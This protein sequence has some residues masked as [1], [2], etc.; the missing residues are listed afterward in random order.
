MF[1][2]FFDILWL[3]DATW[4]EDR[5]LGFFEGYGSSY[6]SSS[7]SAKSVNKSSPAIHELR[8]KEKDSVHMYL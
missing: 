8:V 2:F 6:A 7:G 3:E 1:F 5:G 4:A